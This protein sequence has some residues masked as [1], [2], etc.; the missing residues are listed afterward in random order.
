VTFSC[1]S[2]PRVENGYLKEKDVGNGPAT[3]VTRA[4]RGREFHRE[5]SIVGK[6][7]IL[8]LGLIKNILLFISN[9]NGHT[10]C[11]MVTSLVA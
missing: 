2:T 9:S 7:L 11:S 8:D 6:D 4:E 5:G 3:L 10:A 1:A